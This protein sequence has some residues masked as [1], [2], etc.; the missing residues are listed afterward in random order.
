MKK[1]KHTF[2][3]SSKVHIFIIYWNCKIYAL[4][5]NNCLC[6]LSLMQYYNL[7]CWTLSIVILLFYILNNSSTFRHC[8]G[9]W[10]AIASK[11]RIDIFQY[12]I[13]SQDSSEFMWNIWNHQ[14]MVG[15]EAGV[16]LGLVINTCSWVQAR[17]D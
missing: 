17:P 14:C 6:T 13:F 9:S 12:S 8:W 15:G 10:D 4:H 3:V 7:K 11:N 2:Q 16:V 5:L 1:T